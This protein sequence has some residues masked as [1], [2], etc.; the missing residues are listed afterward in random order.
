MRI[1]RKLRRKVMKLRKVQRTVWNHSVA[2]AYKNIMRKLEFNTMHGK[3]CRE[4]FLEVNRMVGSTEVK[5]KNIY[6]T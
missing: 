1:D 5:F 6:V 4:V 2:K 3:S